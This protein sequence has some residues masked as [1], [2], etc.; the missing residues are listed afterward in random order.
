[1]SQNEREVENVLETILRAK[2]LD[3]RRE[4]VSIEYSSKSFVPD[5]TF[6]SLDLALET[7]LCKSAAK[8]KA[9]I[10]EINADILAYKTCY[11]R[12]VFVI[13]DLGCIR[14]EGRFR[15]GIE[16][17]PGVYVLIIKK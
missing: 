12:I 14:D 5:F 6:D 2:S 13:Y 4:K 10:D 11:N 3:Y 1:M 8:E 15:S 9:L 7:K 16:G 17:N